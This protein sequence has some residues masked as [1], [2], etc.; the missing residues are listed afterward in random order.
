MTITEIVPLENKTKINIKHIEMK[1]KQKTL[2]FILLLSMKVM[3]GYSQDTNLTTDTLMKIA[4]AGLEKHLN[5]IKMDNV[6]NYG[7]SSIDALN[8]IELGSPIQT[9]MF[10]RSFYEDSVLKNDDYIVPIGEFRI[11][12]IVNDTICSFL[13]IAKFHNQWSVIGLGGNILSDRLM[14]CMQKNKLDRKKRMILLRETV[15]Q[16]DYLISGFFEKDGEPAYFP[17]V[18]SKGEFPD[19]KMTKKEILP[20]IHQ[21]YQ[22]NKYLYKF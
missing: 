14:K 20:L 6:K 9:F 21:K 1:R 11:P 15:V 12:L 22:T 7:F 5:L 3:I 17:V 4:N 2:L 18:A 16:S 8:H 13:M 10:S 19:K